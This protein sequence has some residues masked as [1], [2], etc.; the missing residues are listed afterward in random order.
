MEH[1]FRYSVGKLSRQAAADFVANSVRLARYSRHPA[2][3]LV[4]GYLVPIIANTV[5]DLIEDHHDQRPIDVDHLLSHVV[6]NAYGSL[7]ARG[8]HDAIEMHFP[9]HGD[10]GALFSMITLDVLRHSA[11]H[12]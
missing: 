7:Q 3:S 8:Y 4:V 9:G 12:A 1:G 6:N 2:F 5:I 11:A 10:R